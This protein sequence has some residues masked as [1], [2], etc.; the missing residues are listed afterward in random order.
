MSTAVITG[1]TGAIG[2]AL[3]DELATHGYEVYAVCR[4]KSTRMNCIPKHPLVHIVA[5]DVQRIDNLLHL[6]S[7]PC[8]VFFHFAWVGVYGNDRDNLFGQNENVRFTLQAVEVAKALGC[9]TFVG[10][11]SQSEYGVTDMAL[12]PNHPTFP[13]SGYGVA[14]LSAGLFSRLRCQ[15]LGMHHVWCRVLSVYGPRD[16]ETSIIMR[17]IRKLLSKEHMPL[18]MG[19][20]VWDYLYSKDAGLA[21]RLA[22]EKGKNGAIY[23]LGSGSS[24]RLCEYF[25]AVRDAI[26]PKLTLGF[27]EVPYYPHQAIHLEADISNLT[28]DT[29]FLPQYAFEEGIQETIEWV[30]NHPVE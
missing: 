13:E 11:G 20:Q 24:R 28:A 30:R 21:F 29:G 19:E 5:C 1:P 2:T 26:D 14:K 10:A 7:A 18:T 23:V 25:A 3:I 27:G 4:E 12:T 17:L 15:Q 22:A 16:G 6:I 8:D 9:H